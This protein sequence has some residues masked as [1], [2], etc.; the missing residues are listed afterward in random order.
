MLY[1]RRINQE[2]KDGDIVYITLKNR[3]I[4][5]KEEEE[6]WYEQAFGAQ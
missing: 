6:I 1:R 2:F 5:L 4:E 3:D